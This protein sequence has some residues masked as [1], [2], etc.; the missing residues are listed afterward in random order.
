MPK[1]ILLVEDDPG[2]ADPLQMALRREGWQVIW[3]STV[4]QA[5]RLLQQPVSLD[6]VILDVGLPD[7]DGYTLCRQIR[8]QSRVPVLF[9][10]ARSE[11]LERVLGLELGAD[12][13]CSKPF[14]PRELVARIKAIWRRSRPEG[15]LAP[16]PPAELSTGLSTGQTLAP[17]DLGHALA[18]GAWQFDPLRLQVHYHARLL[19]LTRYELRLLVLLLRHPGRVWSR[20][21][22]MQQ[23]WDHPEHSLDR[24][25]DSHIKTLRHKLRAIAPAEDPIETHRGLGYSLRPAPPVA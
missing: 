8:Q 13:Y 21:Q 10:T 19:N 6:A 11:E 4:E 25:V 9:L 17:L 14:S 5:A 1:N 2:I 18:W 20:E 16:T 23:V 22:L 3:H 24:T 15:E 7:G 12:D